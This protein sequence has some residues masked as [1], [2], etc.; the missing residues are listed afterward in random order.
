MD[1]PYVVSECACC[2]GELDFKEVEFQ[3]SNGSG[4]QKLRVPYHISCGCKQ[5]VPEDGTLHIKRLAA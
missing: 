3:C 4:K 2:Q 5:C 1:P